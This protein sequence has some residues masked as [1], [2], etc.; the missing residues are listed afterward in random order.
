MINI[1]A[2]KHE[3]TER[4]YIWDIILNPNNYS[5]EE[6]KKYI[7]KYIPNNIKK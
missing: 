4:M 5:D 7:R 3:F 6:I 2:K 1:V